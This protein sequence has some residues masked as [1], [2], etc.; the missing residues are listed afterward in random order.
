MI[1]GESYRVREVCLYFYVSQFMDGRD[2]R[3]FEQVRG[4]N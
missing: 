2:L 3:I 1:I 4:R